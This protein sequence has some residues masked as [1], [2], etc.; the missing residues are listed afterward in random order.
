MHAPSL[1]IYHGR[2]FL[3]NDPLFHHKNP[4]PLFDIGSFFHYY[5]K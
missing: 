5:E 2:Q 4:C 1:F 3:I